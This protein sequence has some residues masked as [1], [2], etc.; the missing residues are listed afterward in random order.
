[1]TP[2][3]LT[4][5][6]RTLAKKFHPDRYQSKP[7]KDRL[8]AEQ[9]MAAL[10]EAYTLAKE[11]LGRGMQDDIYGTRQ[12]SRATP[13]EGSDTGSYARTARRRENSAARAQR[14]AASRDQAERAAREH[15]TQARVFQRLRLDARRTAQYGDA[16]ARSKLAAK[17]PSTMAGA[18]QAVHT[19]ELPCRRCRTIQR[20][21]S[22]WHERLDDTAYFCSS[23]DSVLLCR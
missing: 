10:N 11:R 14:L 22:N 17:V 6:F 4:T 12:R 19:N 16:V 18:G 7:E 13:W 15:E 5:A 20:L 1:M 21:P 3:E 8:A 9:K 2:A 23:C